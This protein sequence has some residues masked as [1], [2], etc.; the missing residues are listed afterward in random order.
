[1]FSNTLMTAVLALAPILVS[2]QTS[3]LCNPLLTSCAADPAFGKD[4]VTC[5]FTK[6]PCSSFS[7][8]AGTTIEYTDK[9]AAFTIAGFGQAPTVATGKYIFFGRVDIEIQAAAGQGIITSAV[10]QSD[11]LDEIDWEWIGG[12]NLQVQ[13]NYFSKGDVTTY[14]RGAF[15]PVENPTGSFHVYSIEWTSKAVTWSIGDQVVR[16]LTY[17][18]AKGGTSFPQTPMQIKLGTWVGGSPEAAPGTIIWAGGLADF[19]QGPFTGYYKSISVVD[20]AGTDYPTSKSVT[21]YIY[22]DQSGS[23]QSIQVV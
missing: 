14:D 1:M 21:E 23:Y 17:D 2:A 13:T 12:D 6:G 10:L 16:T 5:D 9:G 7:P 3:T 15:H 8:L 20:Y 18:E 11:D 22:G 19:S 4:T